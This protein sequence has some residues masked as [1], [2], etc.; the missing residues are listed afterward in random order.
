M[1]FLREMEHFRGFIREQGIR[2]SRPREEILMAFLATERHLSAAELCEIVRERDSGIGAA[3]VYRT[4]KLICDAGLA[5]EVDFDD[6]T[7]RFEHEFGHDH[8][9]HLVCVECGTCVEVVSHAIETVQQELAAEHGFEL[10]RHK[11][12]LYGV[13]PACRTSVNT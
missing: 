6:G 11:L 3:T 13:C 10:M 2:R 9:D 7:R 4:L 5:R 8:H 12:V 1:D